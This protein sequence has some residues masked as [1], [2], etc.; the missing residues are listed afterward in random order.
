MMRPLLK[1]LQFEAKLREQK[2]PARLV[3]IEKVKQSLSLNQARLAKK[4][5]PPV[6]REAVRYRTRKILSLLLQGLNHLTTSIR[7]QRRNMKGLSKSIKE[8]HLATSRPKQLH[9][10]L[11]AE[12]LCLNHRSSS[13]LASRQSFKHI[14]PQEDHSTS[15]IK[16][17]RAS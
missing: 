17:T 7:N 8:S 12:G 15:A 11:L 4:P 13:S 5:I 14:V 9:N 1:R 10:S 3:Q 6:H 16:A 2:T